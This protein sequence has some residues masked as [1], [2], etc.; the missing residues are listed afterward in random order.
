MSL[1]LYDEF[2]NYIGPDIEEEDE[3][4]VVIEDRDEEE[5]DEDADQMDTKEGEEDTP[6]APTTRAI[7]LH[8]DKQYYPDASE[9]YPDA[10]TLVQE[11][12]T[13]P[14]SV[15]IIAPNKAK[16][17]EVQEKE[18]PALTYKKEFLADISK[19]PT[20]MRNVALVGHLHHGK[21]T[22]M[23][24]LVSQTH[25]KKWSAAKSTRYTDTLVDEQVRGLSIKSTHMS[26]I[27]PNSDGKSYLMNIIDTPGHVNFSDEVT[28]SLRLCDGVLL[29][30]DAVEGVMAQTERVINQAIKEQLPIVLIINKIDRLILELKLPP[31]DA[32]FKIKNVI[33]EVN[34]LILT[35]S[36]G[37]EEEINAKR[38]SPELGN[39]L[40]SSSLL[41]FSFTL[42]TFAKL[43]S[44]TYSSRGAPKIDP[45][46]F[47]KRLWGDMYFHPSTRGFR[48]KPPSSDANRSFVQFILEPLYKIF[49]QVIGEN[50]EELEASMSEIGIQLRGD[51]YTLD[52]QPL[53]KL[54][55]SQFFGKSGGLVDMVIEHIPNPQVGGAKK[56]QN[57][58]TGPLNTPLAQSMIEADPNGHLMIYIT[59]LYPKQDCTKFDAFGRIMSGTIHLGQKVRVLGEGFIPAEDE[60]DMTLQEVNGLWFHEARYRVDLES[61]T[62]GNLVLIGGVD[63]SIMKTATITGVEQSDEFETYIYR[64]L[65]FD[66]SSVV[67]IAVEPINPSELPKM[68]EGLRKINKS[69]P[70]AI[71][72]VEES[73]EHIVLGTGELY[74]DCILHDLRKMYA[75]IEVKVDDPV[76]S[77]SETVVETS[78]IKCF[79]ETPNKRNKITMVAEPL[80][81][82]LAEDIQ[83]E[84]VV[85][86]GM[87]TKERSE[88]LTK[89]YEWDILASRRVWAFGPEADG[90]NILLDDTLPNEVNKQLLGSIKD[91]VIQG[92]QWATREGPL[93]EEPIRNVKFKLLGATIANEPIH[94][95]GG[96]IIPT[97][98]R[99]AF[100]SFLV[101]TPRLMEPVFFSEIQSP[102]DCVSAIYSVLSRRRGHVVSETPKPGT[103]LHTVKAYIPV[104]DSFGF[105]TDL[106]AH[107][108]GQS[109]A[110]S[111][112]HH[113]QIVPGDPLD[114]S[115]VLRPLEPAPPSHLAREFMVKT[116]RRKGL[117]ED[118]SISKFFDEELMLFLAKENK[119]F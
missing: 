11:E 3:D 56:V 113:W 59:K 60:E 28:A 58:Y 22:L 81:K 88:I 119:A 86:A 66:T 54:V 24:M 69:Y 103:P 80:E 50:R 34:E 18:F 21:T 51:E 12:D 31:N 108:Q 23:D 5:A 26:L 37:T 70:L 25:T 118:V 73:G 110:L 62:P 84:V 89:K 98:R 46:E 57:L 72:K 19:H 10:E 117:S 45:T 109:F 49:T 90:T 97:S 79:A 48:R 87:E 13:Q 17:F 112:F 47:A 38:L 14:L 20:L 99:V 1:N 107:T 100:S 4:Q 8:E 6:L 52:S 42:K 40:F 27:L 63:D 16:A 78:S 95:G 104:I 33:D 2:G 76:V 32:Y 65:R 106:R 43:Y 64:P 105:E 115:I 44:K 96:Q 111:V 55:C 53:L 92:F 93:C 67:K 83:N 15:P 71:T 68:L 82:T 61:C 30:V 35:R 74:L 85:F 75:E 101:A 39:I 36:K 29:L 41:S 9:V 114:K 116:R 94:R 91:S 77:F 102:A 7:V